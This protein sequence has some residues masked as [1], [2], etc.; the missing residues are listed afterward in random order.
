MI[1]LLLILLP[2]LG[3]LILFSTSDDTKSFS[4]ASI[5][6]IA[7]LILFVFGLKHYL[8]NPQDTLLDFNIA[9]ISS[10]S[11]NFHIAWDGLSTLMVGLT[12]IVILLIVFST[13]GIAYANRNKLLGLGVEKTLQKLLLR[14]WFTQFLEVCLC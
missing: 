7:S 1:S 4:I 12:A 13:Q 9:W 11:I 8:A 10:L 3:A 6:S 2:I 5:F 14:C